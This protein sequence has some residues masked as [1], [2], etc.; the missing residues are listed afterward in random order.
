MAATLARILQSTRDALPELH[1]RRSAVEAAARRAARPGGLLARWT[2]TRVGLIAE[3]KRRSPSAGVIAQDLD[4]ASHAAA[5]ARA[6]AAAISVLTDGPFFG[7]SLEDLR[8]VADTA[9]VPVLRKDFILDELQI[10][11]ARAAGA[12][13]VLLIVRALPPGRLAE[14]VACA[15]EWD[16]DPLVEV[17]DPGELETALASG[18]RLIGVNSR[19]LDSFVVDLA[20]GLAL[21][22]RVPADRVAVAES[23]MRGAEDVCRAAE[24]GADLVLIGTALSAAPDP[25]ALAAACAAVPRRGR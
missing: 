14:L 13:G 21:V 18:A 5:Y 15:G 11:E 20:A 7:G 1:R 25:S 8:V 4:P 22:A 16:L 9:G 12:A 24:A 10:A 3:V 6:G 2:P 23:G 17:H 19:N